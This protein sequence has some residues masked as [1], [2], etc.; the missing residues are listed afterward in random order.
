LEVGD[1]IVVIDDVGQDEP[2]DLSLLPQLLVIGRAG[3]RFLVG[4]ERVQAE[5]R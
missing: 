2:A 1:T 5:G 4:D 3:T